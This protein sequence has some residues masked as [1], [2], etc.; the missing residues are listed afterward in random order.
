MRGTEASI[1]NLCEAA[2]DQVCKLLEMLGCIRVLNGSV[3]VYHNQVAPTIQF[4]VIRVNE[5]LVSAF[6]QKIDVYLNRLDMKVEGE[7]RDYA[8]FTPLDQRFKS[9]T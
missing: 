2:T 9:R 8:E 3:D 6:F 1:R 5:I 7:E 4:E